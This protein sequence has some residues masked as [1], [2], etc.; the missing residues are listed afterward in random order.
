MLS[1][2]SYGVYWA[3]VTGSRVEDRATSLLT[4]TGNDVPEEAVKALGSAYSFVI[5]TDAHIG[6]S[7]VDT[8]KHNDFAAWFEKQLQNSD[9]KKRPA[10]ILNLGDTMD[11]GKESQ[12]DEFN[13][14][15]DRLAALA[16]STLGVSD[17]KVYAILGNHDL[18]PSDGWDVFKKTLYPHTSYY[19]FAIGSLTY[20]FLDTGNGTLGNPQ[21]TSLH[22]ALFAD[23]NTKIILMHYPLF[24]EL[25]IFCLQD[26]I[27]RNRLI[28]YFAKTNVK[29]VFNGHYHPGGGYDYGPFKEVTIESFGFKQVALL[30]T[31]DGQEITTEEISF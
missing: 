18:Y 31:V 22:D 10:F 23:S 2:C 26:T 25:S 6:A 21:L 28:S 19:K 27:E 30:V 14:F 13:A 9:A 11:S 16:K 20:Y 15:T 3:T 8:A 17:Y 4:L 12:A 1:A 24:S 29:Y 5:I 7:K